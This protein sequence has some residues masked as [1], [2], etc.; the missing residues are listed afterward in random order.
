MAFSLDSVSK[1]K[2]QR[3]PRIILLG[4]EKIGKSTFAAGANN[5]I[6]L[7]IK[8]EE[9]ID[10][11]DV[12]KFPTARQYGEV[13]EALGSLYNEDH[14]YGAVVVDSASTLEPLVWDETRLQNG[15]AESIEK[16][17]GG[18]GK[19]YIEAL[20]YWREIMDG[21]DALRE[22]KNMASV[23]IGHVTKRD[24]E[25]PVAGTYRTFDFD[26]HKRA[27]SAL[28]RWADCILFA[29][30]KTLIRTEEAGFNKTTK[31]GVGTDERRLYTQKRPA[32]PGGGRDVYGRIPYEL[33]LDWSAFQ[34]AVAD[35]SNTAPQ[36][37]A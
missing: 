34:Q 5:P 25:D 31:R 8:G 26:V 15:N 23:L 2:V 6:F 13:I 33:P 12:A 29:N 37:A 28:F 27:Q 16:V 35:A 14:N 30:T 3:A 36:V 17:G 20:K 32:H 21:L 18:Y 19:G 9:G 4:V 7:P 22:H 11:L 1:G 10:G 24:E